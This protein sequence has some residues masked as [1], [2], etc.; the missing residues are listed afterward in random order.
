MTMTST[1][2]ML[3]AEYPGVGCNTMLDD[4]LVLKVTEASA[5]VELAV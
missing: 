1:L 5:G 4:A 3:G 2:L